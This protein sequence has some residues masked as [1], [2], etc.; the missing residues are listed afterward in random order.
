MRLIAIKVLLAVVVAFLGWK[1]SVTVQDEMPS[2]NPSDSAVSLGSITSFEWYEDHDYGFSI[3]VPSG[4]SRLVVAPTDGLL[5]DSHAIALESAYAVGFALPQS[6][7]VD[8]FSDYILIELIPG[9]EFELFDSAEAEQHFIDPEKRQL[10]YDRLTIEGEKDHA[11][12][13]ELVILQH[14][15]QSLGYTLAFY[16]IGEPAKEHVLLD[17]FQMMILTYKQLRQP[18]NVI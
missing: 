18:F 6:E 7:N 13:G 10:P 3:A 14:G 16:A 15:V 8:S 11:T 1:H 17:A 2:G 5:T 4:W 12:N 9:E